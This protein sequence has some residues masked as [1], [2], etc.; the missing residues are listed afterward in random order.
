MTKY[1]IGPVGSLQRHPVTLHE[2]PQERCMTLLLSDE[3]FNY[4]DQVRDLLRPRETFGRSQECASL[5]L[6]AELKRRDGTRDE[7]QFIGP[8]NIGKTVRNPP[9]VLGMMLEVIQPDLE[10]LRIHADTLA[11]ALPRV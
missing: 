4:P 10:I 1:L 7:L 3:Q 2:S 9:R 5:R 8:Q 11:I 6:F